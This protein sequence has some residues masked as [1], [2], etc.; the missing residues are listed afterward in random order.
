MKKLLLVL[1][2][3]TS[4]SVLQAQNN[5]G[6]GTTS[7]S[8]NAILHLDNGAANLGLLLPNVDITSFTPPIG[9]DEGLMVFNIPDGK[10]YIWNGGSWVSSTSE[11]GVNGNDIYNLNSG[12]VGIGTNNPLNK[13]EINEGN[14]LIRR[15]DGNDLLLILNGDNNGISWTLGVEDGADADFI[16]SNTGD[17]S[18]PKIFVGGSGGSY[19][20]NVGIGTTTPNGTLQFGNALEN[21]K[22]VLYESFVNDHQYYGFGVNTTTLRYQ[23]SG[24][25]ASHVFYA[26]ASATASTE[27][28]R[29]TGTGRLEIPGTS[30]ADGTVGTGV[31]EIGNALRIDPNEIITNTNTPLSLQANNNGDLFVDAGT[32][33]VDASADAVGIGSSAPLEK[34]HLYDATDPTIRLASST[35]T[36]FSNAVNSGT[37][38]LLEAN[39]TIGTDAYGGA[40]TYNGSS[41]LLKLQTFDTAIDIKFCSRCTGCFDSDIARC[42]RN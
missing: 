26:A 37:I 20:G 18:D 19:D 35:S 38:Q 22:L 39:G 9:N 21:R 42:P 25:F 33:M 41:N 29:L 27:L 11:W 31:L 16:L 3:F 10:I 28:M 15:S 34:L 5:V 6:I 17:L 30:D 8:A 24:D 14:A 40:I 7:P 2:L 32:F 13:L 4:F 23:V 12:N 36:A 1:A